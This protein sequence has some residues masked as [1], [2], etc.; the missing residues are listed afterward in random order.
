M[1]FSLRSK[2]LLGFGVVVIGSAVMGG[3]AW[4]YFKSF[5]EDFNALYEENVKS[6]I[7]LSDAQSALWELRFGIANFM[8]WAPEE[9][10]K[11]PEAQTKWYEQIERNMKA[12]ELV[13]RTEEEKNL[14]RDWH[15]TYPKYVDARPHWFE[16][17]AAG[18]LQEAAEWRASNTN[19]YGSAS[20]K[21]LAQLIELQKKL[22]QARQATVSEMIERGKRILL[23]ALASSL[24]ISLSVSVLLSQGVSSKIDSVIKSLT[25]TF[26][27]LKKTNKELV[28]SAQN[29]TNSSSKSTQALAETHSS[30]E[31]LSS[32]VVKNSQNA[33]EASQLSQSS[34]ESANRGESE[35]ENLV[36]AITEISMSAKKIGEVIFIIDD[37]AFQTNLLALNAAVEA[38]RAGEHGKGFA[39]VAEAVRQL[40]QRSAN[41]AKDISV[42]IK[43]STHKT[44][45]GAHI[46][47][48]SGGMLKQI[49][50]TIK[51]VAELNQEISLGSQQQTSGLSQ[52]GK[53]MEDLDKVFQQNEISSTSVA[54]AANEMEIQAQHLDKLIIDLNMIL[55]GKSQENIQ[56]MNASTM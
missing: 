51:Q 2:L 30:V 25:I 12:Y 48:E 20:V 17:Y 41:A 8:V 40:S 24:L 11:I 38:A 13:A 32:M 28:E 19:K 33:S 26:E 29:L 18:K 42:M 21:T 34:S 4:S 23:M 16:L 39:V 52:I 9:R 31:S 53:T 56:K 43:E 3:V 54:Q 36:K 46:A 47:D 14:L 50:S 5:S 27:Q 45:Y 1:S 22:G 15:E 44:E 35:M 6:S 55:S 37:I 7:Y 10:M 49:V